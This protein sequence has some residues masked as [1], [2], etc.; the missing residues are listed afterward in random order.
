MASNSEE[1]I[2]GTMIH[3]EH[4][5]MYFIPD[6]EL[7]AFRVSKEEADRAAAALKDVSRSTPARLGLTIRTSVHGPI[8]VRTTL[9]SNTIYHVDPVALYG[10]KGI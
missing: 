2:N 4:G 7:E 3:A 1:I 10:P 5:A 6:E 8:G 9:S